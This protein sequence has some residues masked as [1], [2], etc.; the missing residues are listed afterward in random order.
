MT[1]LTE[2]T[3]AIRPASAE[4]LKIK[5]IIIII[6]IKIIIIIIIIIIFS[7]NLAKNDKN[8]YNLYST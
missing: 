6:I 5:I 8:I 4:L 7:K 2:K 1:R 3:T